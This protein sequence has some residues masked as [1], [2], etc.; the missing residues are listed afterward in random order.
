[1][2]YNATA[3]VRDEAAET[4]ARLTR[5]AFGN[6]SSVHAAGRSARAVLEE[7]RERL[8]AT[9]GARPGEIYFTSGGTEGDNL[10]VK[11]V[12]ARSGRGH[13]ITTAIE[14]PAVIR[15]CEN[16][17]AGNVDVTY[18]GVDEQGRVVPESVERA[19]RDDTFL[20]S[21]M[22]ANN[23]TGVIQAVD[24]IGEFTRARGVTFHTDAVQAY[25]RIPVDMSE[26]PVDIMTISGHK[27]G[28]PKGVGAVYVR[29]GTGL[30][31]LVHGGGQERGM[32]GGTENV[33]GAAA[34]AVA[35]ELACAERAAEAKRLSALRDRFESGVLAAIPDAR[36]NGHNA[37]R[38]ANTSNIRF[39]GA[40]GEAVLIGLGEQDISASS[41]SACAAG[42]EDPSHVLMAMGLTRRGADESIRFSLGRLSSDWDVD[43]C[44]EVL[45]GL[46]R[47][48]LYIT[49]E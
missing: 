39:P 2:D 26:T 49:R 11:G 1:M 45:P 9:V 41:A 36:I 28:A 10:A 47:R 44:L 48:I 4:Y 37:E 31:A 29:K 20:I 21:I 27:F 5:E 25:G 40:D 23:E 13:V 30:E 32:R 6:P 22:W 18:V 43:H 24:R 35:A 3:P 7:S 12:A 16:I 14:H 19:I 15:A 17:S 46:V 42:Y 34:M 8:A 33:P 38:L